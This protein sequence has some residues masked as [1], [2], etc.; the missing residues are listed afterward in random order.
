MRNAIVVANGG[1]KMKEVSVD[2]PPPPGTPP[3]PGAHLPHL[4]WDGKQVSA[5]A[6]PMNQVANWLSHFDELG[7]RVVVDWT[8]LKGNYDFILRGV[9]MG[10]QFP[11]NKDAPQDPPV[12]IFSAL[13]DQ[14]GLKLE[15]RKAPVE[16]LV[17][18]HAQLPSPN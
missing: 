18:E 16:V 10:S 13:P 2:P 8:G 9:S 7:K 15:S 17:V 5:T 3:P 11:P 6:I 12:S 1:V 14:L 4:I